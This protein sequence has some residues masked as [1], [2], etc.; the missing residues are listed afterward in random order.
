L[1]CDC[2]RDWLETWGRGGVGESRE[3]N[4]NTLSHNAEIQTWGS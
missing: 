2:L 3:V 4:N 1:M